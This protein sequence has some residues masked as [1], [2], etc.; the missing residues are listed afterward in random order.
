MTSK[1][2]KKMNLIDL[3]SEMIREITDFLH[4]DEINRMIMTDNELDIPEFYREDISC[5]GQEVL[6][7]RVFSSRKNVSIMSSEPIVIDGRHDFGVIKVFDNVINFLPGAKCNTVIIWPDYVDIYKPRVF[8]LLNI[9]NLRTIEVRSPFQVEAISRDNTNVWLSQRKKLSLPMINHHYPMLAS[10]FC[11]LYYISIF[12]DITKY[13]W[14]MCLIIIM[15]LGIMMMPKDGPTNTLAMNKIVFYLGVVVHVSE[16]VILH[17]LNS[18]R[19]MFAIILHSSIPI[20]VYAL[21]NF[22][23]IVHGKHLVL[24]MKGAEEFGRLFYKV[25]IVCK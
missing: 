22:T 11:L 14:L 18:E 24:F 23:G 6:E 1:R 21:I 2:V 15:I 19:H 16:V 9:E 5:N 20:F 10:I 4:S 7:S 25:D 17:S 12:G 8:G 3:P 13:D